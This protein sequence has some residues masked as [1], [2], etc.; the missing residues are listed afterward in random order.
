LNSANIDELRGCLAAGFPFVFGFSVYDSFYDADGNGGF[1]N[2]PGDEPLKGGHAV[3]AVGYDD[4]KQLFTVQNSWGT[5]VGDHGYYY[6]PYNYLTSNQLSDDFWTVRSVSGPS[7]PAA[8]AAAGGSAI[9][10]SAPPAA[11]RPGPAPAA[12]GTFTVHQGKRYQ[13]TVTLNWLEQGFATE[14]AIEQKFKDLGFTNVTA[15][16]TTAA[17]WQVTGTW[18]GADTTEPIDPHLSD[19]VEIG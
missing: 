2:L 4:A 3:L 8:V 13:A 16:Q 14:D 15:V 17:T 5:A 6:M 9:G 12:P 18:P 1:V 19:I 10:P 7:D 11:M